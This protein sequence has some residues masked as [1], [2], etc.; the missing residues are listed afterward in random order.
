MV[1]HDGRTD[2]TI[3]VWTYGTI[4]IQFQHL[5]KNPDGE[6]DLPFAAESARR[7]LLDK[8][9]AIPGVTI[10]GTSISKRPNIPLELLLN[11]G[12]RAE[13][14]EILTWLVNRHLGSM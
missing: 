7:E 1:D 5:A 6:K 10:P 14:I 2:W 8:L 3:S 13:F 9:N 12:P 11:P 4:E